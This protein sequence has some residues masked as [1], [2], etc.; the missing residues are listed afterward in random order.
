[1]TGR[2]ESNLEESKTSVEIL[3][4]IRE[5]MRDPEVVGSEI[6]A[7]I[8]PSVDAHQVHSSLYCSVVNKV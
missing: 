5:F 4:Q 1:M 3:S 2:Y 7:Y 8:I 6:H